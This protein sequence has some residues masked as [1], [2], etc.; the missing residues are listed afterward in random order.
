MVF[1]TTFINISAI[2]RR[3][4]L[5]VE[6]T[7][8]T[9]KT[10]DLPLVTDKHYHTLAGFELTSL[11]WLDTFYKGLTCAKQQLNK[12]NNKYHTVEQF[13]DP[14]EKILLRDNMDT[15]NTQMHGYNKLC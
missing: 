7:E 3:S 6:E 5:L 9:E 12:N 15:P 14:T 10:T 4:V 13:Q 2:S 1:K 11:S 8:V